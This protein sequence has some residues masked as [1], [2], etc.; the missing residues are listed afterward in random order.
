MSS[1]RYIRQWMGLLVA[2]LCLAACSEDRLTPYGEGEV[3]VTFQPKL[4]TGIDTRAI[5]DGTKVNQ[6]VV[7]VYETESETM[8]YEATKDYP[9]SE[10]S[11]SFTLLAGREYKILFWAQVK[12]APY[13]VK[14]DLSIKVDYSEYSNAGFEGMEQLDA[15]YYAETFTAGAGSS[16]Q[17]VTLYRPFAQ[18]NF[19]DDKTQPINEQHKAIVTLS[20]IATTFHPFEGTTEVAKSDL[21]F[22]FTDFPEET[23]S[24]NNTTY[25]YVASN[26]LFVPSTNSVKA[27]IELQNAD[28]SSIN[29]HT[30]D[31]IP[32][33]PNK[34]TN[35]LGLLYKNRKF[36][37]E[38]RGMVLR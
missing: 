4:D 30:F 3:T 34:R 31:A 28:G 7:R 26:Y 32:L 12:D 8:R 17:E 33:A 10:N 15:F 23:L 9:L 36:Q 6:L 25:Y 5:G 1:K 2:L 20:G 14:N 38:V 21:S 27:T 19:A 22:T 18:L 24:V 29:S 37:Q 11:L 13:T 16:S 35:V